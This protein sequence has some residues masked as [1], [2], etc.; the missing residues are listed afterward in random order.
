MNGRWLNT[1]MVSMLEADQVRNPGAIV[2]IHA[3]GHYLS[4]IVP[5]TRIRNEAMA[6]SQ[7]N[8]SVVITGL[9][10]FSQEADA[11]RDILTFGGILD[12]GHYGIHYVQLNRDYNG[13]ITGTAFIGWT[14]RH[15]QSHAVSCTMGSLAEGALRSLL[16]RIT[17]AIRCTI[18]M[19]VAEAIRA[20]TL[21]FGISQ[22]HW[23]LRELRM[24]SLVWWPDIQVKFR[25]ARR[26]R[27]CADIGQSSCLVIRCHGGQFAA[28]TT[29]STS[30]STAGTS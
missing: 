14:N 26:G 23:T 11:L 6:D 29:G 24:G 5:A 13:R 4:G 25:Y 16:W 19:A 17:Q 3:V 15:L 1:N 30:W 21:T 22:S 28:S 2:R 9:P 8:S 18:L 20:K 7:V 12:E 27:H 10:W